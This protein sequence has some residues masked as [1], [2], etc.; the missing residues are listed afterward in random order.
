MQKIQILIFLIYFLSK[1][2]ILL[3][4][5]VSY[6]I[7]L[8]IKGTGMKRVFGSSFRSFSYPNKTIINN[9]GQ[10]SVYSSYS[11]SQDSN[12]VEFIWNYI[13]KDCFC[14]FSGCYDITEIDFSNFDT[15][16]VTYMNSMFKD[17]TSLT[18][19]NLSSFDTSKVTCVEYMFSGCYN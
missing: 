10:N 18:S 2:K 17:C 7:K 9:V 16:E 6:S 8:K 15:S 4:E 13:I 1:N 3:T 14:M 11:F 19:L 12:I 5:S